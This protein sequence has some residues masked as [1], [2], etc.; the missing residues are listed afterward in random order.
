MTE[1]R[2]IIGNDGVH[3]L[4]VREQGNNAVSS[5]STSSKYSATSRESDFS[6]I[7]QNLTYKV[8]SRHWHTKLRERTF[9][10]TSPDTSDLE[11]SRS[12][13]FGHVPRR[14]E[15]TVLNGICG[16]VRSRQLTGILGPSGAGKSSL[17]YCLFQNRT[18]GTTGRILV[19][20]K[21]RKKLKVCFIPQKDYLNEW[22][23]VRED[24]IFVSKLRSAR[25]NR[26]LGERSNM[27]AENETE[28]V[29]E[30]STTYVKQ[31]G[32]NCSTTLI[33]HNQN[34]FH[35][36]ELLGITN[37]LDVPI[38]NI[39]GGQKKRLSVARE[40]MSTP[41]ILILD[42]PT[43]G[44][45]SLTCHKTV[46]V[47][48][49][50][51]RLS[52]HPMAVIVTIH[53]PQ[54]SVFNL[55]D[56]TYFISKK[57]RIV[58]DDCPQNVVDTLEKVANLNLPT[59]KDN[60]ASTLIEISSDASRDHI[61]ELLSANQQSKFNERYDSG[62][63]KKLMKLKNNGQNWMFCTMNERNSIHSGGSM[64]EQ[65]NQM[66]DITQALGPDTSAQTNNDTTSAN[67]TSSSS[68]VADE[69]Y[70]SRQ[71]RDCLSGHSDKSFLRSIQHVF[72][73][74]HRSWL[75]VIRNPNMTRSR[76]IFNAALPLIMLLIFGTASG[77]SNSCPVLSSELEI[78]D[79]RNSQSDNVIK[80][81][82]EETRLT[83][84]NISFFCILMYGFGINIISTT[85]SYYPLTIQM[86]KKE[87][88]NGLY[89]AGPYFIGQMLA[90]LPLELFFPSVS[91]ILAYSLSGQIS[92]YLEWRMFAVTLEVFLLCYTVHSLGL[93]FGSIFINDINVAVLSG[94]VTLFPALLLSG[95]LIRTPRMP[96]WMLYLSNISFFKH[97][98]KSLVAARYGFNVCECDEDMIPENGKPVGF[99]GLPPNVKHVLDY[100]FPQN[101]TNGMVMG[102]VFDKLSERFIKAQTFAL[103][104]TSCD[105]VKPYAMIALGVDNS[106]LFRG[107]MALV[108]MITVLKLLTFSIVRLSPYRIVW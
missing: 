50:L 98:L 42:E 2:Q 46:C 25:M 5:P 92:S 17:L 88:T 34:A 87:T 21:S 74:A 51:A 83:M 1:D 62:Y 15:R 66:S 94:Q 85:A 30:G 84:E 79:M 43:T 101:E 105:D 60:P 68:I 81:N 45:D 53:Q 57:G 39:S 32:K 72:I 44:L 73:L 69:Y 67:N 107:A 52:P 58:Y 40:L 33:D 102:D 99:K 90:E 14:G 55:F 8:D 9:G 75:S 63:I 11:D 20:A 37:C 29:V 26:I 86:F 104:I 3:N 100:M 4:H 38:R 77:S 95:F 61:V 6:I 23:T 18:N 78:S 36:A 80:K 10:N 24:L 82:V 96:Q 13:E 27:D 65:H 19:D 35:V 71:L 59:T 22:L 70:I 91:V 47:L 103:N 31:R 89:T 54:R 97:A 56:K 64:I 41:D 108:I 28:Q 48:R 49:D 16:D 12:S 106:D 76:L 93:L 7:W